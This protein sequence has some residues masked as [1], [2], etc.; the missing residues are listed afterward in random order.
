M[1]RWGF[2]FG[3]LMVFIPCQISTHPAIAA[4]TPT[5]AEASA[6]GITWDKAI[7]A[8][9][10]KM[11]NARNAATRPARIEIVLNWI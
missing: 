11:S 4:P 10:N 3:S 6:A 2:R 9:C 5:T 1:V 8:A 7:T